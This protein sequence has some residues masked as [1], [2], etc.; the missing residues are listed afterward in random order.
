MDVGNSQYWASHGTVVNWTMKQLNHARRHVLNAPS[1]GIWN[2]LEIAQCT[3]VPAP[4]RTENPRW[5]WFRK[6]GAKWLHLSIS[7]QAYITSSN[8]LVKTSIGDIWWHYMHTLTATS[9]WCRCHLACTRVKARVAI[10]KCKLKCEL[11]VSHLC[12]L[13]LRVS[14]LRVSQLRVLQLRVS[15]LR[16]SHTFCFKNKWLAQIHL[17]LK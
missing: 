13:H 8:S 4:G 16:V 3:R 10:S 1:S 7:G 6:C 5:M 15:H 2:Q 12:V 14:Q 9:C 11:R 17:F